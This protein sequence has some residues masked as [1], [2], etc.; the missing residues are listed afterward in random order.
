[1]DEYLHKELQLTPTGDEVSPMETI[2]CFESLP[3]SEFYTV[4]DVKDV[5]VPIATLRVRYE[6]CGMNP[7]KCLEIGRIGPQDGIF[8]AFY[9]SKPSKMQKRLLWTYRTTKDVCVAE[10]KLQPFDGQSVLGSLS[11]T[12]VEEADVITAKEIH[13]DVQEALPK[14]TQVI[15]Q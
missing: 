11:N 13:P 6:F 1:M 8:H 9:M 4:Y 10:L 2:L 12:C 3:C 14:F 7:T 15:L 5:A